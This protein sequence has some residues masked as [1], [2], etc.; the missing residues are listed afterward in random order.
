M[1]SRRAAAPWAVPFHLTVFARGGLAPDRKIG[2]MALALDGLD[3]SFS[4]VSLRTGKCAIARDGGGIEIEPAIEF[5]TMLVGDAFRKFDHLRH[6]IGGDRPF[7]RLADVQCFYI[8]PIGFG[9]VAGDV[10]DRLRLF[11]R[12]LF[13]L[14]LT[15]ISIIGQVTDI[16]D[17]DDMGKLVTLIAQHAAQRVG[18]D[19]GAHIADMRIIVD[20]RPAAIDACLA[21]VDGL[22][23]F[24]ASGQAVKEFQVGHGP[25]DGSGCGRGQ[26]P[27]QPAAGRGGGWFDHHRRLDLWWSRPAPGRLSFQKPSQLIASSKGARGTGKLFTGALGS[28]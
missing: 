25:G 2:G 13:H 3:P 1:P 10:P 16:G 17:V 12:H 28:R 5:V 27:R 4:L 7:G 21:G 11:C 19:I 14:V 26:E 24:E 18:K 22:E 8:G 23:D 20:R 9:I 6:I 15:G